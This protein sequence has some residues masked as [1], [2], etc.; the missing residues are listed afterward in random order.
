M[1]Q[2]FPL[3]HLL[4]NFNDRA[5]F[6]IILTIAYTIKKNNSFFFGV[7]VNFR[8]PFHRDFLMSLG[9]CD[10]SKESIQYICTQKGKGNAAIIVIGGASESLE[11][12]PGNATLRLKERKGFAKMA[13]KT[14]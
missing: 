1:C 9:I 11:A 12:F 8:F 5:R 4:S 3:F 14:G 2:C 10:V 13:L 6:W 7:L